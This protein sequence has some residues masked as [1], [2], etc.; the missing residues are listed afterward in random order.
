MLCVASDTQSMMSDETNLSADGQ[1]SPPDMDSASGIPTYC[2]TVPYLCVL[3][4]VL[5]LWRKTGCDP[6]LFRIYCISSSVADPDPNPDPSDPYVFGPPGSGSVSQ[7]YGSGS[8]YHE[9]KILN[10]TLIPTVLWLLFDFL[11]LKNDVNVPSKRN[12][13]KNWHLEG[14][15][16]K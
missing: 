3:N 2:S 10:K 4:T 1:D 6:A 9:A 16:R 7:S 5:I 13:Q 11:S 14:H 12:K 15:W 8:F